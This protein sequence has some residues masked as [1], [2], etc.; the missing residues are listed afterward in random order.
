MI[1]NYF[2]GFKAIFKGFSLIAQKGIRRYA[3]VPLLVNIMLFS[4]AIYI[5]FDQFDDWMNSFLGSISWLPDMIEKAI[6]WILWPLFAVLILIATYYSFTVIANLIAAPFNSMLAYKVEQ[7]LRGTLDESD[8]SKGVEPTA[9]SV[10]VRTLGSET[11]KIGHILK[12]LILLL[13]IRTPE[14]RSVML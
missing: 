12:W 2:T 14:A 6:T 7:Y 1:I 10:A 8:E 5:G 4:L 11:K 9:M 3:V 13:I